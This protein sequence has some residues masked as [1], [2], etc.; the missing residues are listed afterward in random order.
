MQCTRTTS[1]L[2][3][4][5][6][7]LLV[8]W[9]GTIGC[10]ASQGLDDVDVPPARDD[11]ASPPL[12]MTGSAPDLAAVPDLVLTRFPRRGDA[13]DD[14][15]P[16]R[17][18]GLILMGGGPD[19]D[20]AFVWARRTLAGP[21]RP[22]GV[23]SGDAVVLRASGADGYDDY[24]YQLAG[25]RSVQTILL[26]REAGPA[27]FSV[28]T[29]L[30]T[31]AEFVFF[32]GGDQSRYVAWQ[33]TPLLAAV[34]AVYR[35]G[36]VVGGTS[37][38]CAILGQYVYDAVSAGSRTVTSRTALSDPFDPDISFSRRLFA[39]PEL[40]GVITDTHFSARDRMGRL[41][42]FVA[43]QHADGVVTRRPPAV[44][45]VGVDEGAALVIDKDMKGRLLRQS[46][47]AC[48]HILRGGPAD[49]IAA[50]KALLYRS[51]A[52]LRLQDPTQD[53]WDFRSWCGA[54]AAFS[55]S[56]D[57][58]A[59]SPLSP[60]DPYRESGERAHCP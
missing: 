43:R 11:A 2:Q 41:T 15:T 22:D 56:V 58:N 42:S 6:P 44:L 10:F 59:A 45:G 23:R 13:R 28:A 21:A 57:G 35:R 27:D 40:A 39:F 17:G 5:R 49:T 55:L 53:V 1:W 16:P 54:G 37:A 38:G 3:R 46:S 34:S 20:D 31:R 9:M 12:D 24:L 36:G 8:A 32:A 50:G 51:I 26:P 60:A 18:P 7:S 33:A 4:S 48:V 25:F 14:T 29:D 30:V 52:V 19:V 47:T